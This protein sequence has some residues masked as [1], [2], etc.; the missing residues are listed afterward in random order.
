LSV[1][2]DDPA[3]GRCQGVEGLDDHKRRVIARRE[4]HCVRDKRAF[5]STQRRQGGSVKAAED[6]GHPGG[7][8]PDLK[9]AKGATSNLLEKMKSTRERLGRPKKGIGGRRAKRRIVRDCRNE[10]EMLRQG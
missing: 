10:G 3:L 9:A 2:N 5:V 4:I 8:T 7:E 1:S 6:G